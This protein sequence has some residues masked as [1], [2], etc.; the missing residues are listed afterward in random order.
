[1]EIKILKDILNTNIQVSS[2]VKSILAEKKIFMID[3]MGSPGS[4]KTATIDKIIGLLKDKYKFAL[5]EAD[6][7]TSRDSERLAGHNI[8]IIQIETNLFGR[9]CHVE[10]TWVKKCLE[11]FDLESID[12]VIIENIGNLVCPAEFELGDDIRIVVLSIPEGE[13]KPV[14]Y[15]VMF[16]TSQAVILNKVDLLPHLQYS[17]DEVRNNIKSVNPE[18]EIYETSAVTGQ[19][20]PEVAGYISEKIQK[21]KRS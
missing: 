14:K 10:S 4:G 12:C 1:M 7:S 11:D 17:M 5:I 13:D 19:G 2:E 3:M 18:M 9:E 8:P 15:P 20:F 21:K 16:N 6:V